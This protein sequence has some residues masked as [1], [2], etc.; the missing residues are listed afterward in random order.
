MRAAEKPYGFENRIDLWSN[1]FGDLLN[2]VTKSL[3]FLGGYRPAALVRFEE[4]YMKV[5]VM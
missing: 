3:G 1:R 2:S 5:M 4:S